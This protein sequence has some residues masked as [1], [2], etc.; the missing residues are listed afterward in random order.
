MWMGCGVRSSGF[1][2][3]LCCWPVVFTVPISGNGTTH[4][5]CL[6]VMMGGLTCLNRVWHMIKAKKYL[7]LLLFMIY[8]LLFSPASCPP[9]ILF[10]KYTHPRWPCAY[11]CVHHFPSPTPTSTPTPAWQAPRIP[12]NLSLTKSSSLKPPLPLPPGR[13]RNFSPLPFCPLNILCFHDFNV[14]FSH[15]NISA[16]SICLI[17][18]IYKFDSV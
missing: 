10:P 14:S 11:S 2:S 18:Y 16:V 12:S 4:S 17:V 15:Y 9:W 6:M 5:I 1:K 7:I 8:L 13:I 3:W